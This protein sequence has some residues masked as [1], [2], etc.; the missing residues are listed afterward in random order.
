MAA[1]R[2]RLRPINPDGIVDASLM[3]RVVGAHEAPWTTNLMFFAIFSALTVALAAVGIYTM[4]A[5]TLAERAR[6]IGV[7][8]A[9]GATDR[10]IVREVLADG[11]RIAVP[12]IAAGVAMSLALGRFMRACCSR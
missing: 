9:L 8:V 7:R 5:A 6:E 10:R 4:L 2:A 12:G 11:M 3:E 1:V